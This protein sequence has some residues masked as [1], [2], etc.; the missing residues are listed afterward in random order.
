MAQITT[1]TT[2]HISFDWLCDY[3]AS[4]WGQLP[5]LAAEWH[6]WDI[7]SRMDFLTDWP[8]A[9]SYTEIL[10]ARER[11]LRLSADDAARLQEVRSLVERNRPILAQLEAR[12]HEK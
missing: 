2:D 5:E 1:T 9:E 3:V 4:Q 7:E 11:T 10:L 8:V 6:A 12:I